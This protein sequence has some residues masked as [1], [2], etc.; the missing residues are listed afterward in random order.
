[1]TTRLKHLI[2][3]LVLLVFLSLGFLSLSSTAFAAES[4]TNVQPVSPAQTE[5][6]TVVQ[7]Q[8]QSTYIGRLAWQRVG[9]PMSFTA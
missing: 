1:M 6:Q 8:A 7:N 5:V 9:S 3:S 4:Q 2:R